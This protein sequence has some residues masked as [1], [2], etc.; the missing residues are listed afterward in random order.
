[1]T[2]AAVP[3]V[4]ADSC[5]DPPAPPR[6][7][8][9]RRIWRS[10][11]ARWI[12]ATLGVTLL[13]LVTI[14][15]FQGTVGR[16][17][18]EDPRSSTRQ[19]AGALAQLL[20]NVGIRISTA[21]RVAEASDRLD[22]STTLVVARPGQ[23]TAAEARQLMDRHPGRIILLRP[24][25]AALETFGVQAEATPPRPGVFQ[26]DCP[27]EAAMLAGPVQV[28]DPVAAYRASGLTEAACYPSGAGYAYLRAAGT[29][30]TLDLVG[31]GLSN[32]AIGEEG[33]A[34]FAMNLLGSQPRLVWL[35]ATRAPEAGGSTGGGRE[36]TLLPSWWQIG[37]VQAAVALVVVGIWRGRRLGPILTEPLP[38]TVRASE[39]V[40]GHGRLYYRLAARDRAAEAL[41][42]ATRLRLSRSFGVADDPGVLAEAVARR[43][44]RS[45]TEISQL[46]SGP[47]PA[48]D[49][50][51]V[52]LANHLDR[53]ER[54]ARQL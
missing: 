36:P 35:M 39:T 9:G 40:E 27:L 29:L 28:D 23:L 53:L 34:A 16:Q 1:V 22:S 31:G 21:D 6:V 54:E 17:R 43:T 44:A 12:G 18:A 52:A 48:T 4:C 51:L 45:P 25:A 15:V 7:P 10:R 49:D 11:P 50:Q 19:G 26:P 46:L 47:A 8:V 42:T 37:V 3:R 13:V 30:G 20:S 38:L 14:A 33:N 32:A 5:G 24:P 41:R 2:A